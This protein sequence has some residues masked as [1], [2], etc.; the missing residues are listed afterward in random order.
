MTY[1][2]NL[3]LLQSSLHQFLY[4]SRILFGFVFPE[5]ISCATPRI[6][7][8]VISCEAV[9]EPEEASVLPRSCVD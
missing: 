6:L 5:S 1:F 9:G 4:P 2:D 3:Q 8:E 7:A